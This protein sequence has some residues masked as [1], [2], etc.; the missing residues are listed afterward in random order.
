MRAMRANTETELDQDFVRPS[1]FGVLRHPVLATKLTELTGPERQ[2]HR[3]PGVLAGR[4]K[5]P[6]GAIDPTADVPPTRELVFGERVEP[7][8][9]GLRRTR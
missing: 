7:E 3:A 8:G 6:L 2:K 1:P 4:I 5:R 9:L